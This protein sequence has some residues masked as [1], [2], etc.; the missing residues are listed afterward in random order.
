VG[1]DA[2]IKDGVDVISLS[3]DASDG[4]QFNYDRPRRHRSTYKAMEHGIIVSAAAVN[5]GPTVGSVGNGAPG[6]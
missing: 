6:C 5:A 3:I 1:L 2:F 4:A